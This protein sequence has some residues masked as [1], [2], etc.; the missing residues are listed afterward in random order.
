[1]CLTANKK[2][3]EYTKIFKKKHRGEVVRFF[4]E[5][6]IKK[7]CIM[8][9]YTFT[10]INPRKTIYAKGKLEPQIAGNNTRI[11]GGACHGYRR[12]NIKDHLRVWENIYIEL[13]ILVKTND[14]VLFGDCND[15][16]FLK[17]RLSEYS[18]KKIKKLKKL[19]ILYKIF[20]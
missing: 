16:C 1:M 4:K 5:F 17:Y 2:Y 13:P 6:V 8:T 3:L 10:L 19:L 18:I 9:P 11:Y 20:N 14:I 7:D 15:V 12:K